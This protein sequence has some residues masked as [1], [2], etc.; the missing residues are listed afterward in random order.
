MYHITYLCTYKPRNATY[1]VT[2]AECRCCIALLAEEIVAD[3]E[4]GRE[5]G[6][7]GGRI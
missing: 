5:G 6:R 3:R 1:K 7:G 2:R 4:G